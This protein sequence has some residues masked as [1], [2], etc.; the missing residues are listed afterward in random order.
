MGAPQTRRL[1]AILSADIVGYSR[2]VAED[3]EGTL[4]TLGTYRTAIS[5]L[6][7]EHNGRI[8]GTAGEVSL[9]G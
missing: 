5:D 8:F 1:V 6:V 9:S 7:R 3:E 2:L 4:R